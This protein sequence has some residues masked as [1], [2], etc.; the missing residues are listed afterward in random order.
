M[1]ADCRLGINQHSARSGDIDVGA[2]EAVRH[3]DC[4]AR[5]VGGHARDGVV[6]VAIKGRFGFRGRHDHGNVSDATSIL[7]QLDVYECDCRALSFN[8]GLNANYARG[9]SGCPGSP[10]LITVAGWKPS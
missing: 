2:E 6:R 9:G 10:R 7:H 5:W 4:I 8:D 3:V 1:G